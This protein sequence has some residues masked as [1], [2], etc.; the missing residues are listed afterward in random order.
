MSLRR[1]AIAAVLGGFGCSSSPSDSFIVT[2]T[3]SLTVAKVS[4][5]HVRDVSIGEF[6]AAALEDGTVYWWGELNLQCSGGWCPTPRLVPGISNAIAV[7]VG[8]AHACALT[9]VGSVACWYLNNQP[10]KTI[11]VDWVE[12]SMNNDAM[13][14]RS[15]S[16]RV[17][18]QGA[19]YLAGGTDTDTPVTIPL[20]SRALQ[21]GV[22]ADF[23]CARLDDGSV[24]CWG[25]MDQYHS[26]PT[27]EAPYRILMG[28]T[29]LAV[30]D[31]D[32]C[33]LVAQSGLVPV[34]AP[35][36]CWG[37][38]GGGPVG[39]YQAMVSSISRRTPVGVWGTG[40]AHKIAVG[41]DTACTI[42]FDGVVVCWG[43]D[44][45]GEAT[46]R[47][48]GPGQCAPGYCPDQSF[49]VAPTVV[50]GVTNAV[51]VEIGSCARIADGTLTCWGRFWGQPG[52]K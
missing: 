39:V 7:R 41:G 34:V 15:A 17:S 27:Y 18:C 14:G 4:L 46:G 2:A 24:W 9:D 44:S 52:M 28:A 26:P 32:G 30:G 33:A 37:G 35:V 36:Q 43:D 22:G 31:F 19:G 25:S 49:I 47:G 3:G 40:P 45:Y 10:T 38:H 42:G 5:E 48:P 1:V 21:L 51:Q 11:L 23:A 12:F 8:S 20:P 13:C 16:G 50:P 6:T 29:E